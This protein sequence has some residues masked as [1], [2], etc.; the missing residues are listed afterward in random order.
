MAKPLSA[1]QKAVLCQLCGRAWNNGGRALGYGD[2]TEFRHACVFDVTGHNGLTDC[3]QLDYIPLVNY[4]HRM[5]GLPPREDRTP[6]DSLA[7]SL[8]VLRDALARWEFTEGYAAAIMRGRLGPLAEDNMPLTHLAKLLGA[9]GVLQVTYTIISRGRE[10]TR[11]IAEAGG[12]DLPAE[13]HTSA[14]TLPPGGLAEHFGAHLATPPSSPRKT[15]P[16]KEVAHD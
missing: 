14:S 4:F 5:L 16:G 1:R 7:R 9:E 15:R 12:W 11:R 13:P 8:W 10:R 3:D 2:V 6:K